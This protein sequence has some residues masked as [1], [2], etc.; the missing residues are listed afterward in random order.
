[1]NDKFGPGLD[2]SSSPLQGGDCSRSSHRLTAMPKGPGVHRFQT[3]SHGS[4]HSERIQPQT[5]HHGHPR[6]PALV[7]TTAPGKGKWMIPLCREPENDV[8]TCCLGC[9]CPQVLYGRTQFRLRQ[10]AQNKDPLDLTDYKV[11]NGPCATIMLVHCVTN[12]ACK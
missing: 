8:S 9:W 12:F 5:S 7:G 11:I 1:M 2:V 10:M 3:S 4:G 6:T